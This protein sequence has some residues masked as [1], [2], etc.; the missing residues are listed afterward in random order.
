MDQKKNPEFNIDLGTTKPTSVDL[1]VIEV[2]IS[3]GVVMGNFA[4]AL[5]R[6]A[7][8]KNPL[9]YEKVRLTEEESVQYF[10]Y[11]MYNR[12]LS[13]KG[14]PNWRKLKVLYIPSYVQYAMRMIGE[15]TNHQFGLKFVPVWD[16]PMPEGEGDPSKGTLITYEEAL[17]ISDKL[18]AFSEDLQLVQDAMPRNTEGDADVMT[19]ALIARRV[20][21]M[22]EVPITK[23]Y[24][25]AFMNFQLRKEMTFKVMYRLQYD[26]LDYIASALARAGTV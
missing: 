7:M 24:L 15:V 21:S 3:S 2:G 11:L 6:E 17:V 25:T 9:T 19:T 12:I 16:G 4:Q 18:A 26:D 1:E 8:R 14:N 5:V 20:H 23:T 22:K 10:D 13:L